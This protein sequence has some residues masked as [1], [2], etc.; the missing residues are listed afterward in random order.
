MV[1]SASSTT[2]LLGDSGDSAYYLKRTL[3]LRRGRARAHAAAL[4]ARRQ[5]RCA[6]DGL[7]LIVSFGLLLAVMLPG[8][9][10]S[11]VNGAQRWIG[12]GPLQIQPSELAKLALILYG[13]NLL[14]TRPKMT[15]EIRT[16]VPYLGVVGIGLPV[17]RGR[18]GPGHRDGRVLRGTAAM[19]IAAGRE[20][21]APRCSLAAGSA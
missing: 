14:A 1:F 18:A 10:S 6:A 21:P 8:I 20:D 4:G 3:A 19:L 2:S 11:S 5:G 15:R 9:G 12:A 13:A 7:L 17:D 16:L